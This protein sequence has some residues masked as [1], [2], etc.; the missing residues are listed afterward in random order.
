MC[1]V[2]WNNIM[3]RQMKIKLGNC[4]RN[5]AE[6][7]PTKHARGKPFILSPSI[8][9]KGNLPLKGSEYKSVSDHDEAITIFLFI[10]KA[11]W[12]LDMLLKQRN[13]LFYNKTDDD[14]VYVNT[15]VDKCTKKL[16][17][18]ANHY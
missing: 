18:P 13:S 4:N 11:K 12:K 2:V 7:P 9:W 5:I 6:Y 8:F 15:T 14:I 1:I 10:F 3:T 16:S 17:K